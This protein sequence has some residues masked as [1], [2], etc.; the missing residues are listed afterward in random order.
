MRVGREARAFNGEAGLDVGRLHDAHHFAV[1][2]PHDVGRGAGGGEEADPVGDLEAGERL[3]DGGDIGRGGGARGADGG[4]GAELACLGV[5]QDGGHG[6]E[7]ERG[8]AGEQVGNRRDVALVGDVRHLDLG[9]RVEEHAGEIACR[10][11]AGGG[12]GDEVGDAVDWNGRVNNQEA[13]GL[14]RQRDRREIAH[15]VVGHLVEEV[16]VHCVRS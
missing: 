9:H 6:G 2:A 13:F 16:D 7:E 1:P 14:E 8:L 11:H 10:A 15:R 5:R 4:E 12:V 3:G